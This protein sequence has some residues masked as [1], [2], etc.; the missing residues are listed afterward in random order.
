LNC[1]S[2]WLDLDAIE[3]SDG[4]TPLHLICQGAKDKNII[5]LLLNSGCHRDCVNK[6]GKIPSAYIRDKET[7]ALFVSKPTPDYL[8]CLCARMIADKHLK[9]DIFG[10]STSPLN[11]FIVLHGCL[12]IQSDGD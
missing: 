9:T 8:K 3:T 11:K 1:G 7:T 5:K 10:S 6:H 12:C 2:R 4:N